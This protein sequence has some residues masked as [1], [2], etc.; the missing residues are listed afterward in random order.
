MGVEMKT[1]QW[2]ITQSGLKLYNIRGT[3]NHGRGLTKSYSTT[4]G[5][6][7]TILLTPATGGNPELMFP[8]YGL[9][10]NLTLI[11]EYSL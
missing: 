4:A 1:L 5:V 11:L 6:M 8:N 10:D 7:P 9:Q 3:A 2:G